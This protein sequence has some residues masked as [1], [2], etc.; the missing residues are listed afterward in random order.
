MPPGREQQM[1]NVTTYT[2]KKLLKHASGK[3]RVAFTDENGIQQFVQKNNYYLC[4][5]SLLSKY[6]TQAF[7]LSMAEKYDDPSLYSRNRYL[8]NGKELVPDVNLNWYDYGARMYDP[9]LGRFH[10]KDPLMEWHFNYTPYHYCANN[11]IRFIDPDG[12]EFTDAAWAYVNRLIAEINARQQSNNQ[13]IAAKRAKLE[14]GGLSEKQVNRLNRQIGR[15]ESSNTGLEQTRGEIATLAASDQMYNVAENSSL[16]APEIGGQANGIASGRTLFNNTTLA[17][18]MELPTQGNNLELFAHELKHAYQFETG[19][20]SIGP[21]LSGTYKNL[22][23]DQYDELEAFNRGALFGGLSYSSISS[24]PEGYKQ[25]ATGPVDATTHPNI[26]ALLSLPL[27][28]QRIHLQRTSNLT[29]HVFRINGITYY[30]GK[31]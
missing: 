11:P 1:I 21:E 15:L 22:L 12:C 16:N 24:L 26:S 20:Y 10:T 17:I 19:A 29:R 7:G 28:Q 4:L 18:D 31:K 23:Y 3:V 2:Y 6:G 14:A 8:N 27:E 25:I 13:D 30:P 5:H 9:Q